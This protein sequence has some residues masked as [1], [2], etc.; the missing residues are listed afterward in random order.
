M[1]IR[2]QRL[3]HGL[4]KEVTRLMNDLNGWIKRAGV[5]PA[6]PPFLRFYVIDMKGVMDFEVGIPVSAPM[7]D[8]GRVHAGVLPAGRYASLIYTGSG[9]AGNKALIDWVRANGLEFDRWDDPKGDAFRARYETY[10]TDP[11]TEPKKTKWQVEVAIKLADAP[12]PTALGT[13]GEPEA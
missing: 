2:E 4:S 3:M 12:S 13:E 1:G 9:L 5:Q 11:K 8:S 6:G 7:P 10:L